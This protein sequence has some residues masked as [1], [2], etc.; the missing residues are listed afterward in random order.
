MAGVAA[1]ETAVAWADA[2]VTAAAAPVKANAQM[3]VAMR[4]EILMELPPWRIRA[5]NGSN[6]MCGTRAGAVD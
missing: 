5:L 3:T 2:P 6:R 4:L 1:E